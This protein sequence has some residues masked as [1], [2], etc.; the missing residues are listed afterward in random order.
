MRLDFA[1]LRSIPAAVAVACVVG[2]GFTTSASGQAA[3]EARGGFH[4]AGYGVARNAEAATF[5]DY[6]RGERLLEEWAE[7]L[8]AWIRLPRNVGLSFGECGEANATYDPGQSLITICYELLSELSITF[9][10]NSEEPMTDDERTEAVLGATNFIFYHELGHALVDVLELPTLGRNED[11]ADGLAAYILID[12]DDEGDEGGEI[13][14]V[15]GVAGLIGLRGDQ[16]LTALDFADEHSLTEQR[17]YNVMC[18]MYGS[19]P[20]GYAEL[21]S[22]GTLPE[23]R[24]V[25][26]EEEYRTLNRDWERLLRRWLKESS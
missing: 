24:A 6:V 20:E 19:D 23:S 14:A 8:N 12:A 10:E 17:F 15:H 7:S 5:R 21:V 3:A 26:C 22:E 2:A 4:V 18:L 1:S 11:A 16:E 9:E 25:R 13:S